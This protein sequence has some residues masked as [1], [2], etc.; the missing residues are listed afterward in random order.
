MH[1]TRVRTTNRFSTQKPLTRIRDGVRTLSFPPPFSQQCQ[2]QTPDSMPFKGTKNTSFPGETCI[3]WS[4]FVGEN[5]FK[6]TTHKPFCIQFENIAFRVHRYFFERESKFFQE[7]LSIPAAPG[8]QAR[9]SSD[10]S[11]LVF[12]D[13]TSVD[14]ERLLWV[15]YNPCVGDCCHLTMIDDC[16]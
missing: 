5:P 1:P 3:S 16:F 2:V 7:E 10:S 15:F 9:G 4:V 14:F 12:D 11:A 8:E 13:V 6:G